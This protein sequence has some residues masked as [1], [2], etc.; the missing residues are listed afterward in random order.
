[1]GWDGVGWDEMGDV[2]TSSFLL[3]FFLL[4]GSGFMDE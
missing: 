2:A 4:R 3:F 1:M